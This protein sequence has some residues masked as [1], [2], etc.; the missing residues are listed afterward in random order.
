MNLKNSLITALL[1]G[2]AIISGRAYAYQ[3]NDHLNVG[4]TA[5]LN[6]VYASGDHFD[7]SNVGQSQANTNTGSINGLRLSRAY[8]TVIGRAN[9][10]F[11]GKFTID[12]AYADPSAANGRGNVF[13]K[14]LYGIYTPLK[15]TQIRF[16]LTE[17]PWIPYEEGV[18]TY[19]FLAQ[20]PSDYEGFM[21]S[22][23]YGVAIVGSLLNKLIEYHIM[24]SNGEGYQAAQNGK[25][26]AASARIG[27]NLKP[28]TL[29]L[30]GLDESTHNGIPDYNPK[31][32]IAMLMY[33]NDILRLAGDYL[34]ADDHI[35]PADMQ[36]AKFNHGY[37]Y[38]FWG[39][40]RIPQE[41]SIRVF[42]RYLYMKPNG[43]DSYT[44]VSDKISPATNLGIVYSTSLYGAL[45]SME[46][47]WSLIG[48]SYDIT[49]DSIIALDYNM[50]SAKG[51]DLMKNKTTYNDQSVALNL[52]VGF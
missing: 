13:V 1:L 36:Y 14:Y 29:N 48:V 40:L 10:K 4:V 12:E 28:F 23:D 2:P 35:T 11:S 16:G 3:I 22:S 31:R 43:S 38:S 24:G 19:R 37:G 26:Y 39:F 17:T 49:K 42:A 7:A 41:K 6:G 8:L 45:T 27:L 52:Q 21:P 9:D 30:F 47:S 5:Y 33:S 44:P 25:G 15:N 20:T 51:Y 46:N 50:F 34:W 18:W 32:A